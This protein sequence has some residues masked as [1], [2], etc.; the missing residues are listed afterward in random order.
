MWEESDCELSTNH[1]SA[2]RSEKNAREV[3]RTLN[4]SVVESER[5]NEHAS[6]PSTVE[7]ER[8]KKKLDQSLSGERFNE[9]DLIRSAAELYG[10]LSGFLTSIAGRESS[11]E[12]CRQLFPKS[13]ADALALLDTVAVNVPLAVCVFARKSDGGG[14]VAGAAPRRADSDVWITRHNYGNYRDR[15]QVSA[16]YPRTRPLRRF[17]RPR[18]F[19]ASRKSCEDSSPYAPTHLR[20]YMVS[21]D[22][23][24]IVWNFTTFSPTSDNINI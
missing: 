6:S 11:G 9:D 10:R 8:R 16:Y 18:P 24:T 3:K 2:R 5:A 23:L 4:R 12:N 19:T 14:G 20:D 1:I 15:S 17:P 13:R 21:R 7:K 22:D